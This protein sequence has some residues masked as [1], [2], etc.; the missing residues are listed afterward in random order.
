RI[1]EHKHFEFGK[2]AGTVITREYPDVFEEGKEPY[3]P[4]NDEKNNALY[5]RYLELA[6]TLPN[7]MFGGRLGRYRYYDMDQVVRAALDDVSTIIVK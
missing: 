2:G 7:V 3:Y 1:I 4:V 5:A 6:E